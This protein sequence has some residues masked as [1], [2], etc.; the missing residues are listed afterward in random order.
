MNNDKDIKISIIVPIYNADKYLEKCL[1]SIIEQTYTDIEI[2]LVNDGSSDRSEEICQ[3]YADRDKRIKYVL[4]KN[5]GVVATRRNGIL[6]AS[7]EYVTFV[8]ADDHI[9]PET[10]ETIVNKLDD[11]LADVIASDILEES[12][13]ACVINSN[14]IKEGFYSGEEL[15]TCVYPVMLSSGDWFSF[16]IL[17]TVC[18]KLFRREFLNQTT[19]RID[20]SITFGEDVALTF[21]AMIN[22]LSVQIISHASYHYIKRNGSMMSG[23]LSA[24]DIKMLENTLRDSFDG[25]GMLNLMQKQLDE[26]ITFARLLKAPETVPLVND[27]FLNEDKRIALYGAGGFGRAL[28]QKYSDRIALWVDRDHSRY[29]YLD[30]GIS[31]IDTL[32][33]EEDSFDVIFIAITN[34]QLC[35]NIKEEL[36]RKKIRKD[37][38]Y[39]RMY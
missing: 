26:Y 34:E 36:I 3:K 2:I 22:A 13:S 20:D 18:A 24:P 37:I 19:I 9:E 31:S 23:A 35:R 11:R 5:M 10:Y 30:C 1:S 12:G 32:V 38:L 21:Q 33:S 27:F 4:Q 39:F 8:D 28:F 25:A 29:R 14:R 7:G 17:P 15:K 6:H 16:G